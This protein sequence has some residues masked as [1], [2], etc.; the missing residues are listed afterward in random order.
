MVEVHTNRHVSILGFAKPCAKREPIRIGLP[1]AMSIG[2]APLVLV[3]QIAEPERLAG[4]VRV[5]V[6]Q[7]P[8]HV[9]NLHMAR[10]W[11]LLIKSTSIMV[12][13]SEHQP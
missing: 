11:D 5:P 13:L 1:V 12:A 10:G 3:S 6:A 2:P 8:D 7:R 9:G 4:A